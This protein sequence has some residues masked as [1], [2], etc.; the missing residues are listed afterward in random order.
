MLVNL[1]AN[2]KILEKVGEGAMGAVFTAVDLMTER[3]AAI[4]VLRPELA[5]N[6]EVVE[7]F[8]SEAVTL[9]MLNH[10]NIATL[11]SFIRQGDDFFIAMEFVRG[12]TLAAVIERSG[13]FQWQAAISIFCQILDGISYAHAEGVVHRDIKP[14]NVMLTDRGSVKV[15]DFGI[16]KV[17]RAA[18]ITKDGV[19]I[20]TPAYMSPEQILGH[21]IDLRSD[22]YSLGVLLYE[23][24]TG[25]LPFAGRSEYEIMKSHVERQPPS[26]RDF[27]PSILASFETSIMR[28]LEKKADLRFQTVDEFRADLLRGVEFFDAL[29][30]TLDDAKKRARLSRGK[31]SP[32]TSDEWISVPRGDSL[33]RITQDI[34]AYMP[35]TPM[36]L[37]AGYPHAQ[38]MVIDQSPGLEEMSNGTPFQGRDG[39]LVT[40]M[41]EALGLTLDECYLT[42][43]IKCRETPRGDYNDERYYVDPR[44]VPPEI[45]E[46]YQFE[47]ELSLALREETP[48]ERDAPLGEGFR[49]FLLREILA[50]DPRV[51]LSFGGLTTRTLLRTDEWIRDLRRKTHTLHLNGHEVAVVPTFRPGLLFR[52]PKKKK[53][54]W[55]DAR[56]VRDCLASTRTGGK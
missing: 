51:V 39:Q 35:N 43:A 4:K 1:V 3:R 29:T 26:P 24:L 25:R 52:L 50:V 45:A 10:P 5:R 21:E 13:A 32:I 38:L 34:C 15:M 49:P 6:V 56:L 46:K 55:K 8:R 33:E 20:G 14:S 30:K 17:L 12:E 11:Y 41:V 16:A 40:K 7:R 31:G 18:R 23:M 42:Y 22:I 28:A 37:G 19:L 9:A 54:F 47:H 48:D 2:Y 44:D 27:V 53:G 36:V